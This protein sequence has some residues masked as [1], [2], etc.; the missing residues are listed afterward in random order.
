MQSSLFRQ[1]MQRLRFLDTSQGNGYNTLVKLCSQPDD[2]IWKGKKKDGR[3]KKYPDRRR[4]E[5]IR[6]RNCAGYQRCQST[7]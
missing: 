6:G 5:K 2:S 7:G 4:S 3:K 1:E